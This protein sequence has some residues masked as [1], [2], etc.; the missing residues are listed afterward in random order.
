MNFYQSFSPVLAA[1]TLWMIFPFSVTYHL[2]IF[3]AD[4]TNAFQN[5]LNASSKSEIIDCTPYYKIFPVL[6]LVHGFD[7]S[8]F[9]VSRLSDL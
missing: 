4:V 7:E 8:I 6:S 5:T 2:T 3:I 1:P 9:L